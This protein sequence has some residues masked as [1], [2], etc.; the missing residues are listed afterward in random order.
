M[1]FRSCPNATVEQR[2]RIVV[3]NV[4]ILI[5]PKKNA[6]AFHNSVIK[7]QKMSEDVIILQL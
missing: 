3:K 2:M 6:I 5:Q 7:C 4:F 1:F